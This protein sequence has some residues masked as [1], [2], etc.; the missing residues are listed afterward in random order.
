M[1]GPLQ[2]LAS[3][4]TWID[5]DGRSIRH[6]VEGTGEPVVLV[7]EMGGSLESWDEIAGELAR[8]FTVIRYD[9]RSAGR[10]ETSHSDFD[11]GDLARDLARLLTA[12]DV[13]A[14]VRIIAAAF[15]AAPAVLLAAEHPE[16]VHSLAL[17]APA[18]DVTEASRDLLLERARMSEDDGMRGL[19]VAALDRAWPTDR[20]R[21][22]EFARAR[23]RYLANDPLGYAQ[24]NRA[25]AAIDLGDAHERVSCPVLVIGGT[26][27]IVRPHNA[28]VEAARRFSQ[29]EHVSIDAGHFMASEAPELVLSTLR[30]FLTAARQTPRLVD[31]PESELDEAQAR[32][33]A[34]A[35]SGTRGRV[36]APMRAWLASPEF[37]RRAQSLGETLR[38]HTSLPPRLSELA[39]LVTARLWRSPYEWRIHAAAAA[40]AGLDPAIIDALRV[41]HTPAQTAADE[42]LVI[43]VAITLHEHGR[44]GDKLFDRATTVL[45]AAGLAELLGILGYY[46]LVSMTLNTYEID[47]PGAADPFTAT[48]EEAP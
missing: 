5:I 7:H 17:L 28:T 33:V 37:A 27:D 23:G 32:A 3:R 10:S 26:A 4:D 38:Y 25:L 20:R 9:Q 39:I 41:G 29:S 31:L 24:H 11:A 14:P 1:P 22:D 34:E 6:R 18:L 15:G 30:P 46:T 16:Q 21:G 45:G 43:D 35:V 13:T 48:H 47:T 12:L 8:S 36:P 19:L 42:R 44:I 40:S 2:T